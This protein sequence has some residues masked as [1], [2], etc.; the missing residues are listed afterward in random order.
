MICGTQAPPTACWQSEKLHRCK[1]SAHINTWSFE[2]SLISEISAHL[3]KNWLLGIF[4]RNGRL[5]FLLFIFRKMR[6]S[7]PVQ[8]QEIGICFWTGRLFLEKWSWQKFVPSEFSGISMLGKSN[9]VGCRRILPRLRKLGVSCLSSKTHFSFA[10]LTPELFNAW[11]TLATRLDRPLKSFNE[12]NA[13]R[14]FFT[15]PKQPPSKH[16]LETSKAKSSGK[17]IS[18]CLRKGMVWFCGSSSETSQLPMSRSLGR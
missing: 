6:A 1:N 3:E 11:G 12:V 13:S 2:L 17:L 18:S 10:V 7:F 9:V 16:L 14:M 5:C 4:S 15:P 8:G